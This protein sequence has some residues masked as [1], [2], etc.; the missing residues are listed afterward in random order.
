[1]LVTLDCPIADVS[2]HSLGLLLDGPLPPM[3]VE[4]RYAVGNSQLHLGIIGASHV[5]TVTTTKGKFREEISCFA[6][7]PGEF[8]DRKSGY[9]LEVSL[10]TV[11]DFEERARSI[12][13][14]A[15]SEEWLFARF[16]GEGDFHMT[17]VSGG[18]DAGCWWWRTYHLYP[19]E[20]IIVTTASRFKV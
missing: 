13:E 16:P 20:K 18:W 15:D 12:A 9:D 1:M 7:A 2:A 10:E 14:L 11:P 4:K 6:G 19:L 3:L 17:A 5:A 8:G